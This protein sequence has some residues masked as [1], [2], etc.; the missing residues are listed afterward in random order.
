MQVS[1]RREVW[2]TGVGLLTCLGEGPDANWARLQDGKAPTYDAKTFAPYI[3]HPLSPVDFDRQ[4]P[5]KSDQRQMELWQRIGVYAA[6]L[7]LNDAGIAGKPDLLDGTD[8]IVAAAGGERDISADTGI[9]TGVRKVTE[10][11][12]FLNERLMSDLRPTLFLA[13]L[14]N[15]LAG[16]ISIV[17]GVVG[18]SRTFLGEEAAG[19]DAVRI[20]QARIAAGQ[21]ELTLV[22]G[23]YNGTRWDVL[24]VFEESGAA[25]K[26]NF[27]PVWDRGAPGGFAP[28]SMG[29]FLVLE[30][31][32]HAQARGARP[33]A[34]LSAVISDRNKRQP[35]EIEATLHR[36]WDCIAERIDRT[37]AG[38]ISG[39]TGLQPATAAEQSV[40]REI[41]LPVRNTGTYIGHGME[42]QFMANLGIAC[43][44][45][46]H[47]KLFAPAGTGD[48]GATAA[49][50]SQIVVTS[51]GN[52]RGEGL[53]LVE[54]A[55]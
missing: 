12:S 41:G 36:E 3:V 52:W 49:E 38:V 39:A 51:V 50:I 15:L 22:G 6:G 34:R 26:D 13:Q 37:R 29:A 31:R 27:A 8:M 16:N 46:E 14:P 10:R 40:L 20:A 18:S 19:V 4:I 32:E 43:T 47:G 7:A 23:A 48:T 35:G 28:G 11:G 1:G 24:L 30:S 45:L 44:V 9:L 2:I 5:K 55:V 17:H 33:R 21:S 53:A 54:R 42:A 25:L